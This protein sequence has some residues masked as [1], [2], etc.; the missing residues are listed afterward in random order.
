MRLLDVSYLILG[1]KRVRF[2]FNLAKKVYLWAKEIE[3]DG[4]NFD[5]KW[6]G[7]NDI[8]ECEARD[9]CGRLVVVCI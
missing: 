7:I 8:I 2:E 9:V 1:A 3:L 6:D 5:F 4:Y